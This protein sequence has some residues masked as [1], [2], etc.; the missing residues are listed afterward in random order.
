M[1]LGGTAH[2]QATEQ[3]TVSPAG[4]RAGTTVTLVADVRGTCD[5]AWTFFQDRTQVGNL[6]VTRPVTIV[7][8]NGR[9][10]LWLLLPTALLVLLAVVLRL[11]HTARLQH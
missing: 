11:L 9:R 8:W 1:S 5:P 10:L 4:G 2:A 6:P 7:R 3:V